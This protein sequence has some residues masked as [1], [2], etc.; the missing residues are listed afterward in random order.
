MRIALQK[1]RLQLPGF[2][3]P[4]LL[5]AQLETYDSDSARL[6]EKMADW[7]ERNEPQLTDRGEVSAERP[8]RTAERTAADAAAQ[9]PPGRAQSLISLL[10]GIHEVTTVLASEVMSHAWVRPPG[11]PHDVAE[12]LR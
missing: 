4:E 6:L 1:Y 10:R 5:R 2:E 9:L 7:I 11:H 3:L 8:N 12:E